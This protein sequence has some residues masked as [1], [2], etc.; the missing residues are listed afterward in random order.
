MTITTDFA[1]FAQRYH[2]PYTVI[3]EKECHVCYE[4]IPKGKEVTCENG[5]SCCQTHHL[6]RVRAIYQEDQ[7]AFGGLGNFVNEQ[8]E[9]G[10]CCFMC[11]CNIDD[12][13]FS[14]NYFKVLQV[15]QAVE[16]PKMMVRQGRV[17][18][19]HL[20]GRLHPSAIIKA[21]DALEEEDWN[22]AKEHYNSETNMLDT[23][24]TW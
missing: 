13:L 22:R 20:K 19:K 24:I 2:A 23:T 17:A 9:S 16:V 1:T 4:K 18:E 21:Q 6:E 8:N 10:Q 11:R 14:T 15:I 3:D 5:H 12:N 7:S